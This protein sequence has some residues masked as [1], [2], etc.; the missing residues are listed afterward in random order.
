M[1]M[2]KDEKVERQK[3]GS[4][5]VIKRPDELGCSQLRNMHSHR[6]NVARF[7]HH[8]DTVLSI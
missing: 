1:R 5:G 3:E 7:S 4:R 8:L 2:E 6:Q